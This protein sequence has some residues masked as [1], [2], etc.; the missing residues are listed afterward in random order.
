[1]TM[2]DIPMYGEHTFIASLEVG[3]KHPGFDCFVFPAAW[4][5][6]LVQTTSCVG[7]PHVMRPLMYNLVALSHRLLILKEAHLTYHF[8]DDR[9]GFAD[10]FKA[11]VDHNISQLPVCLAA[12]AGDPVQR[13][14]VGEFCNVYNEMFRYDAAEP[15][16]VVAR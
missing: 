10:Q 2:P 9:P 12:F 16:S 15:T 6:K 13:K 3:R 11:Y 1:M 5:S 4:V 14:R 7:I 8:G